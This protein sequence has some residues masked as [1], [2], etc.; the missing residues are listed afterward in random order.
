METSNVSWNSCHDRNPQEFV[1]RKV[2]SY[3]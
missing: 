3:R 2:R 1:H